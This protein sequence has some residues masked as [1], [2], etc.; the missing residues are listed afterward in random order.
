MTIGVFHPSKYVQKGL[1]IGSY[2]GR[3]LQR[4]LG[5]GSWIRKAINFVKPLASRLI[6]SA[7]M[8]RA[9]KVPR[10]ALE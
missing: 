5:L 6:N 7:P 2:A 10:A 1:G 4:G 8:Q 3:S 9:I